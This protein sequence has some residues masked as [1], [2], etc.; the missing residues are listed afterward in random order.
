MADLRRSGG[1]GYA[2]LCAL[3]YR[4]A[5]AAHKLVA[6]VDGTPLHFSKENFSNGCIGTVDV[7]YPG[8]P[9]FLLLAPAL[10]KAQLRPVLDYALTP[11]WKFPFAPHDLGTYPLANG[12]V[13]GGGERGQENQMPV[14]ECGNMLLL[15]AALAR[16]DGDLEFPRRYWP[17]LRKWAAY[18]QAQ[19]LDPHTQLCTDDFAGHLGHNANLSLKAI[20]ALGAFAQLAAKLGE[21]A[22]AAR[23]AKAAKGMASRWERMADDGDHY[24]LAFDRPGTWSQKY[25]LIWDRLLGLGLFGKTVSRREVDYYKTRQQRYGLPLDSRKTYTKLDWLVWT[26]CLTGRRDDFDALTAPI[27]DWLDST[28]SRVPLTDWYETTD[29]RQVGFQA[30]SVVGGLFMKLLADRWLA[31]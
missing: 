18:L 15:V 8:A 23:F 1:D 7:T 27:Y 19:G 30:R 28:P 24:R 10:L 5:L 9:L 3:A 2:R 4:Q 16:A 22:D 12:Q 13:Y 14:E 17:L 11:R 21:K 29:G 20:C 26:A 31:R 25:N 6:D